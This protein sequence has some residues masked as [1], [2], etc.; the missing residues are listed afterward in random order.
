MDETRYTQRNTMS[1]LNANHPFIGLESYFFHFFFALCD[2]FDMY[3]VGFIL[4]FRLK[5]N[6][7]KLI[8][9]PK[10]AVSFAKND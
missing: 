6:Q 9:M 4:I 2:S 8:K 5:L 1:G 10:N 7:A 3:S